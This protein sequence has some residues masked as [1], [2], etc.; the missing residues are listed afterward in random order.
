MASQFDIIITRLVNLLTPQE[1]LTAL[2]ID[3]KLHATFNGHLL[4]CFCPI[5]K[6]TLVRSLAIDM[7]K[8]HFKCSYVPC[9]GYKGG[10]LL[11]LYA[12]AKNQAIR[13]SVSFWAT[14]LGIESEV[15]ELTGTAKN[16]TELADA[17]S[18]IDEL[19]YFP[20]DQKQLRRL[21]NLEMRRAERQKNIVTLVLLEINVQNMGL[22]SQEYWAK[23]TLIVEMANW[24]PQI[25]RG[26]DIVA[27]YSDELI[28]LIL[29]STD[30][31]GVRILLKKIRKQLVD[32]KF[33]A[34]RT[35]PIANIIL[36][37][38]ISTYDGKKGRTH[39]TSKS[40]ITEALQNTRLVL[41]L[42]S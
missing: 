38:S 25:V 22:P 26:I 28:A 2:G 1:V 35:M 34:L 40:L 17:S 13:E 41:E 29:P 10:N 36:N 8:K 16:G 18:I 32:G 4:R 7:D 21:I 30:E 33:N 42:A 11:E 19:N 27:Q 6:D 39:Q 20:P 5:H 9:A 15:A 37:Y 3:Q 14:K 23:K 12:L 31:K 24:L